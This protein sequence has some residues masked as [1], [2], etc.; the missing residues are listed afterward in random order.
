MVGLPGELLNST[1]GHTEV[2]LLDEQIAVLDLAGLFLHV[3]L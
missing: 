2:T 3:K 1:A